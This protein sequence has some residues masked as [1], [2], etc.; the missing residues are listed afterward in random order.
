M[1]GKEAECLFNIAFAKSASLPHCLAM[2][3][4]WSND[5]YHTE[6]SSPGIVLFTDSPQGNERWWMRNGKW[7]VVNGPKTLPSLTFFINLALTSSSSIP[8]ID[9]KFLAK[10]ADL[11]PWNGILN[12]HLKPKTGT[13]PARMGTCSTAV[14]TLSVLWGCPPFPPCE[15]GPSSPCLCFCFL[16]FPLGH[17][18][19]ACGPPQR[20]HACWYPQFCLLQ[21]PCELRC[22]WS[23]VL[24]CYCRQSNMATHF[25]LSSLT[26]IFL[27]KSCQD[28]FLG[29]M[30]WNRV[31][32]SLHEKGGSYCFNES[33]MSLIHFSL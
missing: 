6:H 32:K 23:L 22:F 10:G 24:F 18:V 8:Q 12:P 26:K 28:F 7:E 13:C 1:N 27:K 11:T 2:A 9:F 20:E 4:A 30:S 17:A 5:M 14:Q 21:A 19:T 25:D 15:P 31:P 3:M 33:S 29:G 16:G